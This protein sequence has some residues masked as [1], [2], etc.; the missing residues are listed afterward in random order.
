[1]LSGEKLKLGNLHPTRDFTY[2]KD[3]ASAFVEICK[4]DEVIGQVTN[5]G[6]NSEISIGELAALLGKLTGN[7]IVVN[8]DSQRI[9]PGNSEV[10]RLFCDNMKILSRTSWKPKYDIESGLIETIDWLKDNLSIYKHSL[11]N[12]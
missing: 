9:R 7:E 6:M 3:T 11:Y 10:E 5:V 1:M 2:V 12:V 8:A 4:S